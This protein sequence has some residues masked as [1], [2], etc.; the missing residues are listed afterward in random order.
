MAQHAHR[1]PDRLPLLDP[2]TSIGSA[3]RSLHDA[4]R[5]PMRQGT[6]HRSRRTYDERPPAGCAAR[7]DLDV[8]LAAAVAARL[9]GN[10]E[11]VVHG[12]RPAVELV[13]AGLACGWTCPRAGRP[14][15]WQDHAGPRVRALGRRHAS[16]GSRALPTCCPATSPDRRCGIRTSTASSSSPARCSPRAAR[17]RAEPGDAAR[18]VCI[19]RSSRR[20]R[21]HR[22]RRPA[23]IARTV[24]R[25]RDAKPHRPVRHLPAA[26][27]VNSTG[28][29]SP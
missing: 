16:A 28:S 2:L 8:A 4:A 1:D 10:V 11:Q 26:R 3:A 18:A 12:R 20:R 29:P 17:R 27:R 23:C 21:G 25:R 13:A 9:I 15:Q 14:W 5:R 24:L 6:R 19:A 7:R 22:R